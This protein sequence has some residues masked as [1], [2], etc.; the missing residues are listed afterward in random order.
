MLIDHWGRGEGDCNL[1]NHNS[2][3]R[4]NDDACSWPFMPE[5]WDCNWEGGE[6]R[7]MPNN[8]EYLMK[9]KIQT[10]IYIRRSIFFIQYSQYRLTFI[11]SHQPTSS[12]I[13]FPSQTDSLG[14]LPD[15]LIDAEHQ[16]R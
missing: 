2:R 15:G 16:Q 11:Y 13:M 4:V 1:T 14:K 10:S 7:R 9:V 5:F 8:V 3:Q 12:K 6:E